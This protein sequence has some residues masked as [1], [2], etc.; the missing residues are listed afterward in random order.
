[1]TKKRFSEEFETEK[2]FLDVFDKSQVNLK[3]FR[4]L[5]E[6]L[7]R[8]MPFKKCCIEECNENYTH[9]W[10]DIVNK[11][12]YP[13][14]FNH[15]KDVEQK[16]IISLIS[17]SAEPMDENQIHVAKMWKKMVDTKKKANL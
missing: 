6:A 1:M 15:L 4:D 16:S 5:S 13:I 7:S 14:C 11:Q 17:S 3:A 12:Q 9:Y 10:T 8:G 2:E